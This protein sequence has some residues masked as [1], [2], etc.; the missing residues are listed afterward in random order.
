V[1]APSAETFRRRASRSCFKCS[2]TMSRGKGP[3]P[4]TSIGAVDALLFGS[5]YN[6]RPARGDNNRP[7]GSILMQAGIEFTNG[8]APGEAQERIAL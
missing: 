2:R 3:I 5:S 6:C 1:L 4:M 7:H 8:D